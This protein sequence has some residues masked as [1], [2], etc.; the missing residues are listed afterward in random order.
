MDGHK[1]PNNWG[2]GKLLIQIRSDYEIAEV[3]DHSDKD[4]ISMGKSS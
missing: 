1:I 3:D 4:I 2:A